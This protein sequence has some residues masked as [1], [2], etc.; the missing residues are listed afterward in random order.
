MHPDFDASIEVIPSCIAR[1]TVAK[2]SPI[3]AGEHIA[4][5][6]RASHEGKNNP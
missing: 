2:F 5:K 1:G 4:E 3:K 6:I